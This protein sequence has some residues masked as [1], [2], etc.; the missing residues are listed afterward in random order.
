MCLSW[1]RAE[2]AE[3][4]L[5]NMRHQQ[6]FYPTVRKKNLNYLTDNK[7]RRI[8]DYSLFIIYHLFFILKT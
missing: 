7:L 6:S 8:F 5:L 4:G 3:H 2:K 1:L